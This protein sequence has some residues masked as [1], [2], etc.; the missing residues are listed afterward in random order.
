MGDVSV[1]NVLE[2]FNIYPE[3]VSFN[4]KVYKIEAGSQKYC[5]KRVDTHPEKVKFM[6][7]AMEH[8]WQRGFHNMSRVIKDCY[9]N[10]LVEKD[11][12]VYFLTE[13]I[14]GRY[15]DLGKDQ[16]LM[17]AV[18]L[19]ATIHRK[20][21][22]FNP[23]ENCTKRNDVG[24]LKEK[25]VKRISDLE[26]MKSLVHKGNNSFDNDF[27]QMVDIAL[28]QGKS[29]LATLDVF[30]YEKYSAELITKKPLCHRDYVYHNIIYHNHDLYVIDFE[31][32]VQDSRVTDLARFVRTTWYRHLWEEQITKRIVFLYHKNNPLSDVEFRLL[33]SMLLFPHDVWRIGHRWYFSGNRSKK[34]HNA[35]IQELKYK[36]E[37]LNV[38]WKLEK[39][40]ISSRS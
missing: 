14:E 12:G 29:A 36:T 3:K 32:C 21:E 8:L 23:P 26:K 4:G 1:R 31:Y 39:G 9:G 24:R 13:W 17:M 35:L 25:W 5:L 34:L 37:K 20:G 16:E 40:F 2:Q 11:D 15:V 38:L 18:H 10:V 30:G 7:H 6:L 28:E 33:L 22:G 27:K 19:L